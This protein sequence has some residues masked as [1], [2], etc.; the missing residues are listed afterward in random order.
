MDSQALRAGLSLSTPKNGA[1]VIL[2]VDDEPAILHTREKIL[3]GEGYDV[4]SAAD[5]ERALQMFAA[6]PADLVLLDY[7]MPGIDGGIVAQQ[8]KGRNP[9][10]PVIMVSANNVPHEALACVDCFVSKGQGPALLL[11]QIRKLL[12]D[13]RAAR[14][15]A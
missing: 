6:S 11:E 3:R 12:S 13:T 5:G 8:I 7:V 2:S 10:E 15:R 9:R 4:L 14:N 1:K